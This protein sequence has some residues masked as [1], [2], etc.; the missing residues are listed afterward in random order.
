MRKKILGIKRLAVLLISLT[1]SFSLM[2]CQEQEE[3]KVEITVI[4]GWGSDEKDHV[5]M[6]RIYEDFKKENED[7]DVHLI[8]MPTS[9]DLI[10]KVGDL[11]LVGETP[12]V[13]FFGGTGNDSIYH[14]MLKNDLAVNL[15]PYIEEDEEFAADISPVNMEKWK[16]IEGKLYSVSDTLMLSGGYWYNK[17]I[18]RLA[19]IQKIPESWEEFLEVCGTIEKWSEENGKDIK[20]LQV[21]AEGYLYLAD[22]MLIN[23]GQKELDIKNWT[24]MKTEDMEKIF[25]ILRTIYRYS[26]PDDKNYSYRDEKDLFNEG[27]LAI[28][29]NGVWGAPMIDENI[30]A[31]YA[32]IPTDGSYTMSC[33]SAGL[34]YVVGKTGDGKKEEAA[35]R[36]V[37]Y[38]ISDEVQERILKETEQVP[39]NPKVSI[40]KYK[41]GMPRF[42]QATD[43]VKGADVKI[44]TPDNLWESNRKEIFE[45]HILELLSEQKSVQEF[46]LLLK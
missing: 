40:W 45:E 21:S 18:F 43:L 28:C 44:E 7:V 31:E 33:E 3:E 26:F 29:I 2:A 35:V 14:Y 6:R 12:D 24:E 41:D 42:Y 27:K 25:D 22:H 23:S 38:I 36:F 32:L 15:I 8:S 46:M 13:I 20:P 1:C 9:R 11:L 19:G 17:E 34:G 30:D 16:T 5:A 37:K 10:R 39:V 4:H